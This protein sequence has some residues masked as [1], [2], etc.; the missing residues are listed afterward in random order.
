M[1]DTIT[2]PRW[3]SAGEHDMRVEVAEERFVDYVR[4]SGVW[5]QQTRP[6]THTESV[7]PGDCWIGDWR[8]SPTAWPVADPEM[9][10]WLEATHAG[11]RR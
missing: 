7:T 6:M 1:T 9:T 10:A 3:T 5:R 11:I 8:D 2:Y 4:R